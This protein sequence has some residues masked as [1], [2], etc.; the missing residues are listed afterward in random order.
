MTEDKIKAIL[1]KIGLNELEIKCYLALLRK[2]PQRASDLTK[3]LSIPKAT[4]LAA[5]YRLSDEF[6]IVKRSKK[7]NSYLFLVEDLQDLVHHLERKQTEINQN[8]KAIELLL[9]E[10]RSMQSYEVNK[11]KI[12][13]YEGREGMKQ[14]FEQVLEEAD[15]II[16]YGSNEDDVKYLPKLYPNY[17]ERRVEKKIPVKAIIPALSFNIEETLK[18]EIK[19]LRKTHLIPAEFNYPI[20]VN[21]YK[22]TAVFYSFE[23][24]FALVIKSK[25][26]AQCLRKMFEFAF[27]YTEKFDRQIRAEEKKE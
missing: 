25:P 21:I 4:I 24:N 13:Y 27:E 15:E 22:N 11:P 5:L 16:G 19:H 2:S 3:A 10:L 6:N 12:Y 8:K 23:E 17:Y 14:A 7:K 18:K 20:Q 9:P 1:E 26:M